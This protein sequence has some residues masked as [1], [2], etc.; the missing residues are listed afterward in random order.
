MRKDVIG[1]SVNV[2]AAKCIDTDAATDRISKKFLARSSFKVAPV[3]TFVQLKT[4]IPIADK[5]TLFA[6]ASTMDPV[7]AMIVHSDVIEGLPGE[8]DL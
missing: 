5:N 8:S 1:E 4:D 2:H 6:K 3:G 7:A